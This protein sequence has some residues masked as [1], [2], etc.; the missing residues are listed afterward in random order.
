MDPDRQQDEDGYEYSVSNRVPEQK[1]RHSTTGQTHQ[2]AVRLPIT[3]G[4]WRARSAQNRHGKTQRLP[5]PDPSSSVR[6]VLMWAS[7]RDR[8]GA[9]VCAASLAIRPILARR[10]QDHL[11]Q[12]WKAQKCL[13]TCQFRSSNGQHRGTQMTYGIP[14]T[15]VDNAAI[16]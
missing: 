15:T 12:D 7:N 8:F 3:K 4:G 1:S 10:L 16:G 14:C 5:P 9:V 6:S 2:I 11:I 13:S